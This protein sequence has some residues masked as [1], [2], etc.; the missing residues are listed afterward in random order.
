MEEMRRKDRE[1]KEKEE[2][3]AILENAE[4]GILATIKEDKTPYAI[5]INYIYHNGK[6]YFHCAK[7]V[8][9]KVKNIQRESSVCFTVVGETKV[10]V[11]Q[12]SMR[13]ESVVIFGKAREME[14]GK[15]EILEK[16]LE[17]YSLPYMQE[18][19]L[20]MESVYEK[21]AVYEIDID[22][23]TGKARRK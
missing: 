8:G 17:K 10:L 20:Y 2:I 23:M 22:T 16:I 11:S 18:G 3:E 12:F 13:Y 6:I 19:L 15:W 21:A 7:G 5:P 1:I 4:Y 14:D 9:H